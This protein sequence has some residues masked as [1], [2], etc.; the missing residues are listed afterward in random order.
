P[1]GKGRAVRLLDEPG[2]GIDQDVGPDQILDR[3]EY[4]RMAHQRIDPGQEHVAGRAPAEIALI[5][6]MAEPMLE[7]GQPLVALR[8]FA[9][10]QRRKREQVAVMP[11][12]RELAFRQH[13]VL[14]IRVGEQA[15]PEPNRSEAP[16]SRR[17][18]AAILGSARG[19]S[20][21]WTL[22]ICPST[23]NSAASSVPGWTPT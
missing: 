8:Q 14:P 5:D 23:P 2:R 17:E 16:L 20:T 21:G 7:P 11:V 10:R 15:N 18:T 19:R 1:G 6:R 12:L 22:P 9:R 13:L 4:A 3:I